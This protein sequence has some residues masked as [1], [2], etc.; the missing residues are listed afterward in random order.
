VS[1]LIIQYKEQSY[2]IRYGPYTKLFERCFAHNDVLISNKLYGEIKTLNAIGIKGNLIYFLDRKEFFSVE[3][4][5]TMDCE[6]VYCEWIK[7]DWGLKYLDC[8]LLCGCCAL[9]AE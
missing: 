3:E 1:D 5:K 9:C 8:D 4:F 2:L 7:T 6:I